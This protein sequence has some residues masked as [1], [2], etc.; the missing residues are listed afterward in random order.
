MEV[1]DCI[2]NSRSHVEMSCLKRSYSDEK[3]LCVRDTIVQA[4][5]KTLPS[6]TRKL[7]QYCAQEKL[8]AFTWK[9]G[10][11]LHII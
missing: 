4:Y 7:A 1:N 9:Q 2:R 10:K 3:P 6:V 8:K 5:A 11:H